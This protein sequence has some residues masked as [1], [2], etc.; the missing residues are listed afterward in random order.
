MTE[1]NLDM[2]I[3][4]L[5]NQTGN[6]Y[7]NMSAKANK[8]TDIESRRE[9]CKAIDIHIKEN[10]PVD[11]VSSDFS[12]DTEAHHWFAFHR[13]FYKL[14]DDC[15]GKVYWKREPVL[16]TKGT[17]NTRRISAKVFIE[18]LNHAT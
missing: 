1:F 14:W 9:C 15:S 10:P 5:L 12:H 2:A 8:C 18:G 11:I 3:K 7:C 17:A 4:A 13:N 6:E 16:E